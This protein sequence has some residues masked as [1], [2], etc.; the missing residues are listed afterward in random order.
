MKKCED[1]LIKIVVVNGIGGCGKTTFQQ[2][3]IE[4]AKPIPVSIVSSIDYVKEIAL[5]CG[6]QK[7]SKTEKDRKNLHQLKTLMEDWNPTLIH[8]KVLG[9]IAHI[10]HTLYGFNGK[11]KLFFVDIREP[12]NIENFKKYCE[13]NKYC[14]I[15][16]L[17]KREGYI[18]TEPKEIVDEIENYDYDY[19]VYND[20]DIVRLAEY[21]DVFLQEILKDFYK[22]IDK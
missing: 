8:E 4:L 7:G 5:K 2:Q 13:E 18:S 22:P 12:Y 14:C 1:E 20:G 21:A 15:T 17:I 16:L 19:V 9:T 6:W 3:C 11:P 10:S